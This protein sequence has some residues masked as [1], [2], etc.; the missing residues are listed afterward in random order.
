MVFLCGF[1]VWLGGFFFGFPQKY[2]LE[3]VSPK[4]TTG[5]A[6]TVNHTFLVSAF[7]ALHRLIPFL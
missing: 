3:E 5:T 7:F 1:L 6:T 2:C 4:M